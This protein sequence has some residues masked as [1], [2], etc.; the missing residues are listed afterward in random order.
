M[1]SFTSNLQALTAQTSRL[2]ESYLDVYKVLF[3]KTGTN[4]SVISVEE[5]EQTS[6]LLTSSQ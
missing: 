5:Q 1:T 2:A 4:K 6:Y 3:Q